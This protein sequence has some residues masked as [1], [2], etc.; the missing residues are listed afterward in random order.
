[1][2]TNL[3]PGNFFDKI[4]QLALQKMRKAS[5]LSIAAFNATMRRRLGTFQLTSQLKNLQRVRNS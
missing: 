1:M 2:Q 3:K 5:L 4:P